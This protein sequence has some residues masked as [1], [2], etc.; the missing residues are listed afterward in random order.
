MARNP[1]PAWS[2]CALVAPG[3]SGLAPTV[4][5]LETAPAT[6][7]SPDGDQ[8]AES[9]TWKVNLDG[10]ASLVRLRITRGDSAVWAQWLP[11]AGAGVYTFNWDGSDPSGRIVN[12]GAYGYAI[13]SV[14][15][16]G[17][18]SAA[19]RGYVEVSAAAHL[20]SVWRRQ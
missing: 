3:T 14:N 5:T 20:V 10:T 16:A 9:V 7:F 2:R 17:T 12:N 19:L 1:L 13:D 15:T 4:P 6:S 8:N 18:A 11:V